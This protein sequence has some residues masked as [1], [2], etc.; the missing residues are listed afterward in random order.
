VVGTALSHDDG[1]AVLRIAASSG[2]S[3][4]GSDV[5][6]VDRT[7]C[8]RIWPRAGSDPGAQKIPLDTPLARLVTPDPGTEM[9]E[10]DLVSRINRTG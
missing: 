3:D 6:P 4:E 5:E 2:R 8:V 10:H 9:F 1:A 7:T